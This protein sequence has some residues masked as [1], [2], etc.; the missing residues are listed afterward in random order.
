[1]SKLLNDLNN[2]LKEAKSCATNCLI[3]YLE[4]ESQVRQLQREITKLILK[5]EFKGS[6]DNE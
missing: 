6:D 5:E 3:K 4:A 2:Q 1:M